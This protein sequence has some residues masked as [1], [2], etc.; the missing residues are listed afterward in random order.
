M[1]RTGLSPTQRTL[2]ALREQG[3]MVDKWERWNPFAGPTRADG[4][5]PVGIRQDGFGF[6]DLVALYPGR[7]PC[8]I[9]AIQCCTRSG[10]AAH[11]AKILES[12]NAAAWLSAGGAIELWSWAKQKRARGGKALIWVPKIEA[13]GS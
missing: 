4:S 5:G 9:V 8:G 2:R 3:V 6:I 7:K 1:A 11:R 10:H 13:I 12:E